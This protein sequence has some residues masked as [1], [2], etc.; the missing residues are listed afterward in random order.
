MSIT[1]KIVYKI[2]G[3]YQHY[4]FSCEEVKLSLYADDMVLHIEN[5]KDST[6]KLLELINKFSKVTGYKNNIQKSDVFLY[7]SN[8]ISE[9]NTKINTF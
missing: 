6:P 4:S 1:N 8:E 9:R 7:T 5:P 3:L 2:C